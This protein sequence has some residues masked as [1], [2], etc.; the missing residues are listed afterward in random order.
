MHASTAAAIVTIHV[1]RAELEKGDLFLEAL[2]K[3]IGVEPAEKDWP[4][5]RAALT[6]AA[7]EL[8]QPNEWDV[9]EAALTLSE[10]GWAEIQGPEIDG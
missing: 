5:L 6:V 4:V 9:Q 8:N 1:V 2:A 7:A 10:R 3:K